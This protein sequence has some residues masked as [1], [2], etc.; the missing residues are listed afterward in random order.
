MGISA[1]FT[2]GELSL[3]EVFK[4]FWG[5][6]KYTSADTRADMY[7]ATLENALGSLKA[8]TLDDYCKEMSLA[9]IY[10]NEAFWNTGAIKHI[11]VIDEPYNNRELVEAMLMNL[12]YAIEHLS[13]EWEK[14]LSL[15]K[16]EKKHWGNEPTDDTHQQRQ[17]AALGR[18]GSALMKYGKYMDRVL[19][20]PDP[21]YAKYDPVSPETRKQDKKVKN[22]LKWSW[23]A[24]PRQYR[25]LEELN[26]NWSS[27]GKQ[28]VPQ[29][30]MRK[31]IFDNT[32]EIAK[33]ALKHKSAGKKIEDAADKLTLL[34]KQQI[35]GIRM[36][37][38]DFNSAGNLA[39]DW[40]E[41]AEAD[42]AQLNELKKTLRDEDKNDIKNKKKKS[43]ERGR[44]GYDNRHIHMCNLLNMV[45]ATTEDILEQ[46]LHFKIK[47][48]NCEIT[49][50]GVCEEE[51]DEESS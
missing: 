11:G 21:K 41:Q 22:F 10:A 27:E 35:L 49:D 51:D 32:V 29:Y 39:L 7:Y 45:D 15:F 40:A 4:Y 5:E 8:Q 2:M 47:Y 20:V 26:K 44:Y 30:D 38:F 6:M 36:L 33:F 23:E 42:N 50:L 24:P 28:T 14:G 19:D 34:K 46:I 43:Y 16:D 18:F 9:L 25:S 13:E 37:K 3:K 1:K 48:A 17:G 31:K 12:G